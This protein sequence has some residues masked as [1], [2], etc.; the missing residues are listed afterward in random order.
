[1]TQ[2]AYERN[3]VR[4]RPSGSTS[5]NPRCFPLQRL[6]PELIAAR[7]ALDD[8]ANAEHLRRSPPR[9]ERLLSL[10]CH[11]YGARKSRYIGSAKARLQALWAA[12]LVNLNPIGRH[13]VAEPT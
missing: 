8:P 13:L 5:S 4:R 10:L 1:M 9:I 3:R 7:Q 11:R 12:A 2:S 6:E